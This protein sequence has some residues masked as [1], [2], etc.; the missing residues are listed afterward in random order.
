MDVSFII[1]ARNE[2]RVLSGCIHS[3]KA[4]APGILSYEII[5][6]DHESR[7]KTSQIAMTM[8]A[9]TLLQ[10]GGTIAAARNRG[11]LESSGRVL[12]FIDADV[13]LTPAWGERIGSALSMV[14][15]DPMVVL[16]SWYGVSLNPSWIERY[17]FQ[18]LEKTPHSHVNSGH[19]IVERTLFQ[20]LGGFDESLETGEDYD[21]SQRAIRLGA[22]IC[23]DQALSV[24][25]E[26]YP[27]TLFNFLR[28]ELWHGRGDWNSC[29]SVIKSRV[30][31]LALPEFM[32]SVGAISGLLFGSL[33]A[34][35][36]MGLFAAVLCLGAAMRTFWPAPIR[37]LAVNS[38][39]YYVYFIARACSFV[40]SLL[41]RS[42]L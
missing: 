17:W 1:P 24:I 37:V 18:A 3:I 21:F 27:K 40:P 42:R 41:R 10:E 25:H 20:K 30:L 11:A 14:L 13:L 36:V 8:G 6:V 22:H 4:Y 32:L 35:I 7:D 39:L 26:G 31:L 9:K 23:N 19:M 38:F 16:G 12:I 2:E 34:A 29:G 15:S 33:S 5:V 28:R